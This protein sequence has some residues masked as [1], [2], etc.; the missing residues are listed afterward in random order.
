MALHNSSRFMR[1]PHEIKRG[2]RGAKPGVPRKSRSTD[3]EAEEMDDV[4]AMEAAECEL[5]DDENRISSGE[6]T[7][8]ISPTTAYFPAK[9]E[10]QSDNVHPIDLVRHQRHSNMYNPTDL[11]DTAFSLP[12]AEPLMSQLSAT[13]TNPSLGSMIKSKM[14]DW[15]TGKDSTNSPPQMHEQQ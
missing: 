5:L 8:S 14:T 4:E 9:Q 13:K 7:S 6:Y 12:K 10:P 2:Q 1:P 15:T 11:S 3:E